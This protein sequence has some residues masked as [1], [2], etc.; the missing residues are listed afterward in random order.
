MASSPFK[1]FAPLQ[2]VI[3]GRCWATPEKL[4]TPSIWETEAGSDA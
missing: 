3:V 2:F 4:Q 1:H